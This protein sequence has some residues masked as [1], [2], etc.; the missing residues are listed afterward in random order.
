MFNDGVSR[1]GKDEGKG[2][3]EENWCVMVP[4]YNIGDMIQNTGKGI[5]LG[6]DKKH[7]RRNALFN[8]MGGEKKNSY[9]K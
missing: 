7:K 5:A 9:H 2:K 3:R 4:E 6:K 1:E 8:W